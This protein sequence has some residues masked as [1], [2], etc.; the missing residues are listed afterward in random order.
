VPRELVVLSPTAPDARVLIEAGAAVDPDLGLRTLHNG[1]VHQVVRVD[2]ADPSQGA[3]VVSI[4]QP[5]Q[6]DNVAEV[7]R[8]LPTLAAL[9][10]WLDAGKPVWWVE[11]VAPWGDLGRTG[12]AVVQ[13]MA[14]RLGGVCVVQDGE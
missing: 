3:G 14:A 7:R 1:A 8:L 2:P 11:A 9:P 12:I 10:S 4:M 6:V 5:L 13:E